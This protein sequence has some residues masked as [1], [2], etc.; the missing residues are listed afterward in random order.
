MI[1]IITYNTYGES[2]P[3]QLYQPDSVHTRLMHNNNIIYIST[4]WLHWIAILDCELTLM[5]LLLLYIC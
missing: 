4:N 5:A 1:T 2:C 3:L